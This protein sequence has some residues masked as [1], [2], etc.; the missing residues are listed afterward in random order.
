MMIIFYTT[1]IKL[2]YFREW[3]PA[4]CAIDPVCQWANQLIITNTVFSSFT[5]QPLQEV[6]KNSFNTRILH[7]RRVHI[8][9]IK[10][11]VVCTY[12][13]C[14]FFADDSPSGYHVCSILIQP[15]PYT[16]DYRSLLQSE[17]R[18]SCYSTKYTLHATITPYYRLQ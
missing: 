5:P 8:F 10:F 14:M 18:P 1:V 13:I 11:K 7:Y 6:I 17:M 2:I 3:L 15:Y 12:D 9:S 4:P 16:R